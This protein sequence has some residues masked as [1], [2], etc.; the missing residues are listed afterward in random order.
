KGITTF[1]DAGSPL[2]TVDLFRKMAEQGELGLRMWVMLRAPQSELA[3]NLR[4]YLF[5]VVSGRSAFV[6]TRPRLL[7]GDRC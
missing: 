5:L 7:V 3:A 4:R 6:F 1:E 2:A